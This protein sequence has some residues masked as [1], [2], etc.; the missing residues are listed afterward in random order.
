LKIP[1]IAS[2]GIADARGL[3][4]ALALGADAVNMGTRFLVTVESPIHEDLKQKIVEQDER[5]TDLIFRN[6]RNTARVVKNSISQ[7]V[8]EIERGGGE[9]ADVR[10]LVA[11]KRGAEVWADGD[12]EHGIWWAGMAQGLIHDVPTVGELIEGMVAEA[13]ELINGRL[14]SFAGD[15]ANV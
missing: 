12:P 15:A 11:G 7:Q 2:G 3:V 4:A 9:F 1:I 6:F 5:S 10:E 8:L 14:A 13:T